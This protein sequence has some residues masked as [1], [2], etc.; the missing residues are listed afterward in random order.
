[1]LF[2][3]AKPGSSPGL[4]PGGIEKRPSPSRRPGSGAKMLPY[5]ARIILEV[6]C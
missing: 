4:G 6:L 5:D 1:M 3:N 2:V